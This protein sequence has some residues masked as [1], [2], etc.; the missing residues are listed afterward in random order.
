ML[1]KGGMHEGVNVPTRQQEQLKPELSLILSE[2]LFDSYAVLVARSGGLLD[3][4]FLSESTLETIRTNNV[5]EGSVKRRAHKMA[6]TFRTEGGSV[7]L[8]YVVICS[9]HFDRLMCKSESAH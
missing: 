1:R 3:L 6:A 9:L 2:G 5:L 8:F 4:L 7:L